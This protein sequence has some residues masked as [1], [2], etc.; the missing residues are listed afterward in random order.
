MRQRIAL[1]WSLFLVVVL[2]AFA[3]AQLAVLSDQGTDV[4]TRATGE[5]LVSGNLTIEIYDNSSNGNKI[6]NH[7]FVEGIVNGS[8]NVI[9]TPDLQF[10]KLYYKEYTINND[11]LDFNGSER[12][13]FQAPVG[14][15]NNNSFV[16]FSLISSCAAGSSIRVVNENGSVTCE[17]TANETT[18]AQSVN[19]S[20]L[21]AT[22]INNDTTLIS[23]NSTFVNRSLPICGPD[24]QKL[25][26]NDTT[27]VFTCETDQTGASLS[28]GALDWVNTTKLNSLND[29]K[30]AQGPV[31]S[32]NSTKANV[33]NVQAGLDW[34][35]STKISSLNDSK[36]NL[37]AVRNDTILISVNSSFV[38]RSLPVCGPD[39]QKL[40]Y[41]DTFKVFTCETDQSASG[42][43]QGA[44]DS[45][46]SSKANVTNT[47]AGLDWVNTTKINSF[48]DSILNLTA[49]RN[50]TILISV[51]S[52]FV[53]RSLPVCGPDTQK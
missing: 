44:V 3:A 12:L 11:D 9:T 13:E 26:Y 50:D 36:L 27:K 38:N 24:T 32:L 49:V 52:S 6:Y 23:V 53:N 45:L 2:S 21:N 46:N 20:K 19:S 51:N 10:G 30:I 22:V 1:A 31:D 17:P 5:L 29:S 14:L 47:Q 33:T 42:A 48:N 43:S 35:N 39:S 4:R 28:Q 40:V 25:V 18:L 16:N 37:T 7:T 8:W 15:I 41:N 34:V